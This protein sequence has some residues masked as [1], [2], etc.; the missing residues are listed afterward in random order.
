MNVTRLILASLG[1]TAVYFMLGGLFFALSPL[2]QEFHKY[3]GVYRSVEDMMSVWPLGIAGMLLS[4]AAVTVLYAWLRNDYTPIVAGAR[5]GALLGA[6]A[7]GS[8]V[9]H[10]HVNLNIGLKLT[11]GQAVAYFIQWTI[12]GIVIGWLYRPALP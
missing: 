4:M 6:F 7:V 12:I 2:K 9:L 11:L 10:N 1:A 8:F 5:F 3:P